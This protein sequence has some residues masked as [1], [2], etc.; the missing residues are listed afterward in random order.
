[1]NHWQRACVVPGV[2]VFLVALIGGLLAGI[3]RTL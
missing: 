1:L 3:P 2:V